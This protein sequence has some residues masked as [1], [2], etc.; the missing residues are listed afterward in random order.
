MGLIRKNLK[1]AGSVG[2]EY[3]LLISLM[4]APMSFGTDQ[5]RLIRNTMLSKPKRRFRIKLR[6]RK[7]T[8]NATG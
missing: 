6:V 8:P 3:W 4:K 5:T 7:P 2:K 1:V